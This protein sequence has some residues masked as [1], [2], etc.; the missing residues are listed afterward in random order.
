M[1]YAGNRG[2]LAN[3]TDGYFFLVARETFHNA[4][5]LFLRLIAL[6]RFLKPVNDHLYVVEDLLNGTFL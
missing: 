5:K 6:R 3:F 1:L 2:E 4:E